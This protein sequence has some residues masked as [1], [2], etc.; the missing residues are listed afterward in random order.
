MPLDL[1]NLTGQTARRPMEQ[2]EHVSIY[3]SLWNIH[4]LCQ[5]PILKSTLCSLCSFIEEMS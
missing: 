2:N 1:F 4:L 3:V 5:S